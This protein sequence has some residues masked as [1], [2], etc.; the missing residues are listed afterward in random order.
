MYPTFC[1]QDMEIYLCRFFHVSVHYFVAATYMWTLCEGLYLFI[2]LYFTFASEKKVKV[3]LM[4]IGWFLPLVL[5]ALYAIVRGL[6]DK[7]D[8]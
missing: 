4:L 2:V 6:V 7:T 5:I 1:S 3:C 8:Q